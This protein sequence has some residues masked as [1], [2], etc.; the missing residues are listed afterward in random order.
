MKKYI[1]SDLF[2]SKHA[3]LKGIRKSKRT[4]K[5]LLFTLISHDERRSVYESTTDMVS[6]TTEKTIKAICQD[7]IAKNYLRNSSVPE[8]VLYECSKISVYNTEYRKGQFIVL[9]SSTNEHL[10]FGKIRKLL[11]CKKDNAYFVYEKT[12]NSY[13]PIS[14]LY[15]IHK[16]TELEL[17]P[18]HQLA[19][20][21]PLNAYGVGQPTKNTISMKTYVLEQLK[22]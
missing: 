15:I 21:Y 7:E 8:N 6:C 10:V 17:I 18:Q 19:C 11:V 3:P 16:Q 5:N 22:E 12:T 13:D 9:P 14:D 2:E 4:S 1:C 20:Y